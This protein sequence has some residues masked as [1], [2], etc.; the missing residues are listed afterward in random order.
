MMSWNGDLVVPG[1]LENVE[2]VVW[3]AMGFDKIL[4]DFVVSGI[5]KFLRSVICCSRS[6]VCWKESG[7]DVGF[8]RIDV[9]VG[10]TII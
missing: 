8:S 1:V 6:D 10:W 5:D 3:N 2:S 9:M 7:R 4:S